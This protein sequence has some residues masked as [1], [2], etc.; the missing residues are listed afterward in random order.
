LDHVK[1]EFEGEKYDL[2]DDFFVFEALNQ[3]TPIS[4]NDFNNF[5]DTIF[6]KF[7]RQGYLI[8]RDKYYIFQPFDQN[9]NIPMYHRSVF[10]KSMQTSL[11]LFN[12]IKNT[13]KSLLTDRSQEAQDTS[14]NDN[15]AKYDI[16]DFRSNA[17]YYEN[18]DEAKYV[19]IIDKESNKNN[20]KNVDE[21]YDVFKIRE[22]R[23]KRLSKKRGVGITTL[24]G[25]VCTTKEK[26]E[27]NKIA[28]DLNLVIKND[29]KSGLC[30]AIQEEL[31]FK[32]K[33]SIGKDK[34]TYVMIPFNHSV[35]K[36]P[37]NLEDR[38]DYLINLIKDKIKFKLDIQTK[39]N[40]ET[41]KSK[42]IQT[43]QIDITYNKALDEFKDF[44]KQNGFQFGKTIN[45]KI[46]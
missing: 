28:R 30:D 8:Y 16:Y 35:Y 26:P 27:L 11:T 42:Q 12:Y 44:F 22:R 29:T 5:H 43:Y 23:G 36:F 1:S 18:R 2:F 4:E 13:D 7:N 24:Y 3:L 25:S 40:K 14:D 34:M 6:D 38:K 32:E 9:E 33:Y 10:D 46:E 20:I 41:V 39:T 21:L 15:D 17:E 37:L 45:I 31:I 19:G